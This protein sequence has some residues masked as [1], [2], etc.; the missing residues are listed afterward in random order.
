MAWTAILWQ[1]PSV[2]INL[3]F[4]GFCVNALTKKSTTSVLL[5]LVGSA[6]S[7]LGG[8]GNTILMASLMNHGEI[9]A[10]TNL[11]GTFGGLGMLGHLIFAVGVVL[12]LVEKGKHE[13]P[14]ATSPDLLD[15]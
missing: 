1:I 6:I 4:I 15:H 8:I 3:T 9:A 11:L 7:L 14:A 10:R 5:I 12:L 2:L 13:K